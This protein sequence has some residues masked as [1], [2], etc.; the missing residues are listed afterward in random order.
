[1]S[2]E[3][4]KTA[5]FNSY[6][7]VS[8]LFVVL[9]LWAVG[10]YYRRM[11]ARKGSPHAITATAHKLA[12]IFYR[13]LRYGEQ[14][15]DIGADHYERQYQSRLLKSAIKRIQ[16]LGFEVEITERSTA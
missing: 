10:A 16:H 5:A 15:V 12:R 1:M 11:R 6:P 7:R 14:Y 3:P 2:P 13:M 4:E 9:A 8:F